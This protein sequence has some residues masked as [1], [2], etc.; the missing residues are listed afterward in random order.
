MAAISLHDL[1]NVVTYLHQKRQRVTADGCSLTLIPIN[2]RL[3]WR[4]SDGVCNGFSASLRA[5]VVR[6]YDRGVSIHARPLVPK[7]GLSQRMARLQPLG[8]QQRCRERGSGRLHE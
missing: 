4:S 5:F 2:R 3:E 1:K 6:Y 7:P 8:A